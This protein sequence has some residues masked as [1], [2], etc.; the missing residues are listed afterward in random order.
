MQVENVG[1]RLVTHNE[2][3]YCTEQV[4]DW[5]LDVEPRPG[6]FDKR[7]TVQTPLQK[8]G[9]YLVK[10]VMEG[11]NTSEIVVWLADLA[12]VEKPMDQ[13]RMFYVADAVTGAPAAGANVEFFGWY[14]QSKRSGRTYTYEWLIRDTAEKTDAN[15]LAIVGKDELTDRYRWLT[16]ARTG[17]GRMAF[18][19]FQN[20]WY[21][22]R[23][24][25]QYN[26][27]RTF[28]M[29]D[30][31]VYRPKQKVQLKF[32][33]D[34]SRYDVEGKSEFEGQKAELTII[35]PRNEKIHE[36]TV[37]LDPYGGAAAELTLAD[38]ATLGV[39][40]V[41]IRQGGDYRGGGSFRV[42]EYKK[43]E[44]EVTVEAPTEPVKLGD[45][46]TAEISAK[47]YFGAPV[48]QGKVK[49]KV[50]RTQADDRWYPVAPWD[51]LFGS[52]YWWFGYDCV[53]LPAGRTGAAR[54]R[55]GGGAGGGSPRPRPRS[56]S[57]P[58]ATLGPTAP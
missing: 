7:I 36:T 4:A 33:M 18:L 12:I 49:Y 50:L 14:R 57:T 26:A 13:K 22:R 51:W 53:W 37:T 17:D 5:S 54:P 3:E 48:T 2:R 45:K 19:G 56:C 24:D 41:Q 6:H 46:V 9:A 40:R 47:Y 39:Y 35:S 16:V 52:G 20:Y 10:A 15:G 43:P 31:P 1:Y 30:R 29:T 55:C 38:E 44:F 23:Y 21:G 42:E 34:R 11:G 28:V 27:I 32:W 58:R 25:A 8:G